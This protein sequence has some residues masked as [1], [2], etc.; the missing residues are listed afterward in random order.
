MAVR[1]SYRRSGGLAGIDMKADAAAHELSHDEAEL[2]AQLL[3]HPP[4]PARKAR[5]GGADQFTYRLHVD[6]GER[7]QTFEWAE[8]EVPDHVRPLLAA[9]HSRATPTPPAQP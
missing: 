8:S 4:E 9:L 2:A 3:A 1:I 7:Q 6:D 5:R